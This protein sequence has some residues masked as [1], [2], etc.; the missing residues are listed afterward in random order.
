[1]KKIK[2][3]FLL[4]LTFVVVLSSVR[5]TYSFNNEKTLYYDGNKKE[6]KYFN[7]SDKDLF[8]SFKNLMPGDIKEETIKFKMSNIDSNTN[9]YI[10]IKENISSINYLNFK[11]YKNDTL[12]F[13]NKK[14]EQPELI[15]LGKF[16]K[17]SNFDL[18]LKLE[19]SKETGNEI[20]DLKL[21]LK[22]NF[23]IEEN[24]EQ[25]EVPST[26]DDSNIIINLFVMIISLITLLI[27]LF[28]VKKE[29]S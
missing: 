14:D 25:I 7:L 8:S 29:N 18:K 16:N 9:L 27:M 1:M 3:I 11:I 24:G 13:D 28:K 12:I 6:I 2:N 15:D 26:Y 21:N 19:I 23:I 10:N 5:L 4:F 17:D 20:Q 22:L